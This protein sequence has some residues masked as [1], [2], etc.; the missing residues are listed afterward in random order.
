MDRKILLGLLSAVFV[1]LVVAILIPGGRQ[2][3]TEPR[4]PWQ[5]RIN[6]SGHASVFGLTLGESPLREA[7]Q[8]FKEFGEVNLFQAKD[9]SQ[10]IEAYFKRIYL[11][12]I[13]ADLILALDIDTTTTN[14]MYERGIRQE[15]LETGN[16]KI[17]L[18]DADL[19]EL[20]SATIGHL[21]YIPAA[22]LD[23]D[24]IRKR[25][26]EP[27]RIITEK[28]GIIHWLYPGKGLDIAINPEGKEMIQYVNPGEFSAILEPL[29]AA[30]GK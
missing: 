18:A 2:A 11:S 10:Y 23:T 27:T 15:L 21:T 19:R 16:R 8:I 28:S 30:E 22:D 5:I 7:Q 26:G 4:L 14:A 1:V 25:F 17:T 12:G 3:D 24:L 29:S 20:S 9:G 13:R 6:A